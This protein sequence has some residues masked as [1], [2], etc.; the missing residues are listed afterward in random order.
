[1]DAASITGIAGSAAREFIR[2]GATVAAALSAE[3]VH[4]ALL[5]FSAV[6]WLL[7]IFL[8]LESSRILRWLF[9][10]EPDAPNPR[11]GVFF[12]PAVSLIIAASWYLYRLSFFSSRMEPAALSSSVFY[13]TVFLYPLEFVPGFIIASIPVMVVGSLKLV[14]ILAAFSRKSATGRPNSKPFFIALVYL[15]F[16]AIGA[17]ASAISLYKA[18]A[19]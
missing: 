14:T 19:R 6:I 5:I 1:M 7:S 8:L 17:A 18:L 12:F 16:N 15:I 3:P 10:G 13:R 2:N 4:F 11:A 9:A